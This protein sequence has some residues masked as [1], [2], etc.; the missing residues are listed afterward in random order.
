MGAH[1][2]VCPPD[3]LRDILPT[4]AKCQFAPS[5]PPPDAVIG[6]PVDAN[7]S[8]FGAESGRSCRRGYAG[9]AGRRFTGASGVTVFTRFASGSRNCRRAPLPR[10]GWRA[11]AFG[12][13]S[14]ARR[15]HRR[16]AAPTGRAR[17]SR[18]VNA[19]RVLA[20]MLADKSGGLQGDRYTIPR[21]NPGRQLISACLTELCG[22]NPCLAE[23]T[24]ASERCLRSIIGRPGSAG[25]GETGFL[26][27]FPE[28]GSTIEVECEHGSPA[29]ARPAPPDCTLV[30]PGKPHR[31]IRDCR[32]RAKRSIR[33]PG[34]PKRRRLHAWN[35]ESPATRDR[36]ACGG[37]S[38]TVHGSGK[39]VPSGRRAPSHPS[40]LCHPSVIPEGNEMS[41]DVAQL[42][43]HCQN[44]GMCAMVGR[45]LAGHCAAVSRAGMRALA[46]TR[47]RGGML[48]EQCDLR[49]NRG[50]APGRWPRPPMSRSLWKELA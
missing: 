6:R 11:S 29:S 28:H 39:W 17:P 26:A 49:G 50:R 48:A 35:S 10:G 40:V 43:F 38:G 4:R 42:V 9:V 47:P 32:F 3:Q 15:E 31:H 45:V 12:R 18:E 16:S 5:A 23:A 34:D 20:A 36:I 41:C 24:A 1:V 30:P 37:R 14:L 7:L 44:L 27:N 25:A 33:A 13:F 46:R 19:V 21:A 8:W 2:I 22:A